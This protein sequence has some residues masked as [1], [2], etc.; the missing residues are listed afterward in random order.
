L[1]LER[2][3]YMQNLFFTK[4]FANHKN[5]SQIDSKANEI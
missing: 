3:C 1:D 4:H 5:P 2:A